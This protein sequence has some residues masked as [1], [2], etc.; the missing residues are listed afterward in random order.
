MI[1]DRDEDDLAHG[2]GGCGVWGAGGARG[3]RVVDIGKLL[4]RHEVD[5]LAPRVNVVGLETL[6]KKKES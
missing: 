5:L 3:T 2:A 1:P 4:G 6:E